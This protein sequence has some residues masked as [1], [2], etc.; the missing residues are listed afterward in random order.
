MR[1]ML[2]RTTQILV[3][4]E[5]LSLLSSLLTTV[6]L[7]EIAE[8]GEHGGRRISVGIDALARVDERIR[9]ACEA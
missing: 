9:V 6:L 4:D 8:H 1:G 7:T 5:T 2:A 3:L